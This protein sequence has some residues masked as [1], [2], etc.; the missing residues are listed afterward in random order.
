MLKF[1]ALMLSLISTDPATCPAAF[2]LDGFFGVDVAVAEGA[3]T[4]EPDFG[5]E[6]SAVTE[7]RNASWPGVAAGAVAAD[8]ATMTIVS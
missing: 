1:C 3:G 6:I 7:F 8:G 5:A 4:R 2:R